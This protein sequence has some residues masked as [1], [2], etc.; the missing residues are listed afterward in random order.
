MDQTKMIDTGEEFSEAPEVPGFEPAARPGRPSV[1]AQNGLTLE[2]VVECYKNSTSERDAAAKLGF[3]H[4][5]LR[6]YL[7]QAGVWPDRTNCF[8]EIGKSYRPSKVYHWI[9]EQHGRVP[10]SVA[11]IAECSGL[12]KASVRKF[13]SRRRHAA[14]QF[15]LGLGMLRDLESVQ[16]V[17]I[18]GARF[19]TQ[20]VC[21]ATLKVDLYDLSV[22]VSA[23][24]RSGISVKSR[25]SF[26]E[27][28][29]LF[30][31]GLTPGSEA[32]LT[33]PSDLPRANLL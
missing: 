19:T 14:E 25:M 4:R 33:K 27:Y 17:S 10:R 15:L 16:L 11:V 30:E 9:R 18:R 6:K 22:E 7:H 24:L 32:P 12:S 21:Q 31:A 2:Q 20:Q 1:L 8:R 13:L 23:M 5:T 29:R 3:T 28:R 26:N